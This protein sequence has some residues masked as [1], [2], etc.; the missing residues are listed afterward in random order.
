MKAGKTC[1]YFDRKIADDHSCVSFC[2]ISVR[3]C[4]FNSTVHRKL[5]ESYENG[6][7]VLLDGS[8]KKG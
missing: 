1:K 5:E 8:N 4:G 3:F 2:G 7:P 6:E